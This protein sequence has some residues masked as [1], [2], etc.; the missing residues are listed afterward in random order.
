MINAAYVEAFLL[1][2]NHELAREILWRE[3]PTDLGGTWL[4]QFWDQAAAGNPANGDI[5]AV[6]DWRPGALGSHPASG[7]DPAQTLV[8]VVK[9]KLLRR[10]PN[11]LISATPA[12]WRTDDGIT[13]REED[14]KGTALL[15]V[16]EGKLGRHIAFLG[17]QFPSNLDLERD[18]KGSPEP[19]DGRPG[20][21]FAFEQPPTEPA[22]GLDSE[23]SDESPRLE[24]WKDV[25]WGD[26]RTNENV[27]YVQLDA[28]STTLPYDRQGANQ[29][30]ETWAESAAAM[31]RITLQRPVRMLV[32]A[33]EMLG[34]ISAL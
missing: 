23:A 30:S 15:P 1:G 31:A 11:T 28:L 9:G 18:V 17:F 10:Y 5:E 13:L 7:S 6:A 24:F 14:P 34:T 27:P 3:Y 32:H 29:W 12:R 22:F 26:V 20:W 2:A 25:T 21:Y 4:R 16:F 8:L 33:D 19:N